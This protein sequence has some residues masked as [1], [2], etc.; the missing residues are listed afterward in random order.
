MRTVSQPIGMLSALGMFFFGVASASSEEFDI[1]V[2][3]SEDLRDFTVITI[4]EGMEGERKKRRFNNNSFISVTGR[5][6]WATVR[7][8]I[9]E[10]DGQRISCAR[11]A[12]IRVRKYGREVGRQTTDEYGNPATTTFPKASG[13]AFVINNKG[14]ALTSAHLVN[15][16][17]RIVAKIAGQDEQLRV[18]HVSQWQSWPK[19]DYVNERQITRH[20]DV[21][22]LHS[23]ALRG[24]YEPLKISEKTPT[25]LDSVIVAGYPLSNRIVSSQVKISKGEVVSGKGPADDIRLFQHAAST[26]PGSSG[27]PILKKNGTVVGIVKSK[28]RGGSVELVNFGVKSKYIARFLRSNY[29]KFEGAENPDMVKTPD[30]ISQLENSVF[31]IQCY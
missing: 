4:I 25:S 22:V 6:V 27:G 5:H 26:Q 31:S 18:E 11:A 8:C 20:L 17:D 7:D 28:L 24:T 12:S 1:Q 30:L 23:Y 21:A 16:C 2:S 19:N 9:L 13:T 15:G 3:T 29:V 10:N 14:Y